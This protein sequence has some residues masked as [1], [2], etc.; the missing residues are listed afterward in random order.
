MR[1]FSRPVSAVLDRGVLPGETDRPAHPLRVL[2]DVDADDA[3]RPR[4]RAG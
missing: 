2:G 3:Q 4:G 1:R